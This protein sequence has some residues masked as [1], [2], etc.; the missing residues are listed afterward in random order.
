MSTA[1]Q[2][3]ELFNVIL[4]EIRDNKVF[5]Q[6]VERIFNNQQA[7]NQETNNEQS[8]NKVSN[9]QASNN[10]VSNNEITTAVV[11]KKRNRRSPA[12]LNPMDFIEKGEEELKNQLLS[13]EAEQLKDIIAEYGMDPGRKTSKW[14]KIDRFVNHIME[15]T[16]SR[17]R[18]GDAFRSE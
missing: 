9:N 14:R 2:L 6:K 17:S 8:D 11:R 4:A 16:I 18:L 10:Q 5:A 1:K 3:E 15:M 13:L 7:N 12:I